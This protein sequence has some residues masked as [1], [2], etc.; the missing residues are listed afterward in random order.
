[1][2]PRAGQGPR[3]RR[4]TGA[5][6]SEPFC[7]DVASPEYR[8]LWPRGYE[9]WSAEMEVFHNPFARHPVPHALLS[10]STYWF[11]HDGDRVCRSRYETRSCGRRPT[12]RT[13]TSPR[14]ASKTFWASPRPL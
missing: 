12:S 3:L 6:E 14:H 2:R 9:P 4:R 10:E 1:L 11:E 7:L 13:P 8:G 5:L